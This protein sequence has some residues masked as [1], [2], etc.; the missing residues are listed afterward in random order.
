MALPAHGL[1]H[2]L[3]QLFGQTRCILTPRHAWMILGNGKQ[4]KLQELD[5]L[6]LLTHGRLAFTGSMPDA[7]TTVRTYYRTMKVRP[8]LTPEAP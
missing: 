4:L 2:Y 6:M 3:Q 7:L 5:H 1:A 8:P